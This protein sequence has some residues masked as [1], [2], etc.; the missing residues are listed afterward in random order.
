MRKIIRISIFLLMLMLNA[1]ILISSD[2]S[3]DFN[4]NIAGMDMQ[5]LKNLNETVIDG[6]P[7]KTSVSSNFPMVP[8]FHVSIISTNKKSDYGIGIGYI[9][10]GS[11]AGYRDY[12]G[13]FN[14]DQIVEAYFV[15]G[16]GRYHIFQTDNWQPSICL[17]S[18]W[19]FSSLDL[20][21]N[22]QIGDAS[23]INKFEHSASGVYIKPGIRLGYKLYDYLTIGFEVSY[24]LDFKSTFHLPNSSETLLTNGKTFEIVRSN[25]S[26]F[27]IG[28]YTI[29]RTLQ[30]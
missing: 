15:Y 4:V 19:H 6:L 9:T 25:W 14:Y 27:R 28:F 8:N 16:T 24:L 20:I 5:T 13:S 10:S 23:N 12:S 7:F 26:G 30:F 11:R 1:T 18:G 17:E 2:I 22:I 29:F 21:K 3:L